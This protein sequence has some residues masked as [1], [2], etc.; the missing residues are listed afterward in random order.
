MTVFVVLLSQNRKVIVKKQWIENSKLNETSKIFYSVKK[1]DKAN[2]DLEIEDDR[3]N[4][5]Q[6]C[7]SGHIWKEF[8]M[9]IAYQ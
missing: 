6:K 8:S 4:K 7:Y 9:Y 2:F 5:S 3:K 1:S